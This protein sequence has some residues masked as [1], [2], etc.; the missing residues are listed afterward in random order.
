VNSAFTKTNLGL[1]NGGA[2]WLRTA[3][4]VAAMV[5]RGLGGAPYV[6]WTRLETM[7]RDAGVAGDVHVVGEVNALKNFT[8]A[9]AAETVWAAH[10]RVAEGRN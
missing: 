1:T 3:R 10:E 4:G 9:R 2:L 7:A 6:C 5:A 8:W